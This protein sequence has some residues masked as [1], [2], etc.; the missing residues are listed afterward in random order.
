M[1]DRSDEDRA[2]ARQG[3]SALVDGEADAGVAGR[4][5]AGWRDDADLRASWH[6]YQL[7]GDVMRSDEL[8]CAPGRD[9]AF[10]VALRARLAAEPVILAPGTIAKARSAGQRASWPWKAPAAVAA[11]FIAIAGAVLVTQGVPPMA[12]APATLASALGG[13]TTGK[14]APD[15]ATDGEPLVLVADR[16]L[17]RDAGL[18][19]YLLAHEQFGGSSA[20]GAPSGFLRAATYQ[21]PPR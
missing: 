19:R 16:Q 9:S 14:V 10:L 11:G 13:A 2:H 1:M 6:A 7:I 8:A 20:L 17:M 4:V 5:C 12:D 18:Q 21:T 15:L 3:L